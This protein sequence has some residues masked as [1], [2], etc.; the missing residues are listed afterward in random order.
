MRVDFGK[1]RQVFFGKSPLTR[2][3]TRGALGVSTNLTMDQVRDAA[4]LTC[5]E[6]PVK[7]RF[8]Q[9]VGPRI[10]QRKGGREAI[11]YGSLTYRNVTLVAL[12]VTT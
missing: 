3:L 10:V 5:R 2:A 11:A 12:I 1:P 9:P 7:K 4:A 6:Y 8:L